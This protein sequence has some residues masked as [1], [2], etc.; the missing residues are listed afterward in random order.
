MNLNIKWPLSRNLSCS[1]LLQKHRTLKGILKRYRARTHTF[2][3]TS[4]K[5]SHS[6]FNYASIRSLTHVH[7]R[8][9]HKRDPAPHCRTQEMNSAVLC[10]IWGTNPGFPI[11]PSWFPK[12]WH[13]QPPKLIT[14]VIYSVGW[15]NG[16]EVSTVNSRWRFWFWF[17]A[18][19]SLR[20][21][22]VFSLC[23]RRFPRSKRR[24]CPIE[25]GPA[26]DLDQGTGH[27]TRIGPR[28]LH[29]GCL[30]LQSNKD[31]LN[32]KCSIL[33]VLSYM[34]H[35]CLLHSWVV[36]LQKQTQ[37]EISH[38]FHCVFILNIILDFCTARAYVY[39]IMV[40]RVF[41]SF[42]INLFI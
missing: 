4:L 21:A 27:R 9:L 12:L 28:P 14:V 24:G 6:S 10:G 36:S 42:Q 18:G 13:Y 1:R 39:I 22:T 17:P 7:I 29:C 38:W 19:S 25:F 11:S 40:L 31:G 37:M 5:Q 8:T 15:P 2:Y 34:S 23:S 35:S 32:V 30:L 33:S 41:Y 16:T 20:G 26:I 3:L